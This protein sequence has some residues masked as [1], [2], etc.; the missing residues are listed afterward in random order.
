MPGVLFWL[1][2]PL[3]VVM[4]LATILWFA[5]KGRGGMILRAKH[6]VL[7]GLPTMWRKPK[8]IQSIRIA[9]AGKMWRL[10]QAHR[11][12]KVRLFH[13]EPMVLSLA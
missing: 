8:T 11:S 6:D 3:H 4:N 2:L 12:S 9:V 10:R 5:S 1:L 7:L 13:L